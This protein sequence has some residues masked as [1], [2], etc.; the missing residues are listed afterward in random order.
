M[1]KLFITFFII[2]TFFQK[3]AS[4]E[5]YENLKIEKINIIFESK[6]TL[7]RKKILLNLKTKIFDPFSHQ[8]FDEDLKN[9]SNKFDR[10]KSQI[11]KRE[12]KLFI[13]IR[14]WPYKKISSITFIGNKYAKDKKLKKELKLKENS[15]FNLEKFK[16]SLT[17]IK[18]Y[19]IKNGYFESDI[20]YKI[21]PKEEKID[22]VIQL[23]EGRPG[24][25]KEVRFKGI[26]SKEK[27]E[28][29]SLMYSKKYNIL[30]SWFSGKGILKKEILEQ[31]HMSILNYLNNN[32]YA[33]AQVKINLKEAENRLILDIKISKG[34]LYHFGK[35]DFSGNKLFTNKEIEKTI[36]IK[37]DEPFSPEKIRQ[38]IE[39]ITDLYGQKGYIE[40]N[41][42]RDISLLEDK[43]IYDIH[44]KIEEGDQF[45]IGLIHICGNTQTNANVI[46]RESL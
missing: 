3:V 22:I 43:P 6:D 38:T 21:I 11:E 29:K 10:V 31:D 42:F 35:I 25:I 41:I 12:N 44:F 20:T 39:S 23:K 7:D 45:K 2:L 46:L 5:E 13:T 27:K 36:W 1:K 19:Y 9:L 15:N 28:I 16:K 24:K 26:T 18:D 8:L 4:A 14:L 32:G 17:N 37:K 40:T 33:D 34:I 30:H